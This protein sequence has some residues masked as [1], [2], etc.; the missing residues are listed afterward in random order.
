V[1]TVLQVTIG[2]KP[3]IGRDVLFNFH[4]NGPG[5]CPDVCAYSWQDKGRVPVY[6][7]MVEPSK[8]VAQVNKSEDSGA[9]LWVYGY[10]KAGN[11]IRTEEDGQWVNGYRVPTIYGYAVPDQDAPT[12][13]RVVSVRKAETVGP[14]RLMSYDASATTGTLLGVFQHDETTPEYRQIKLH[15]PA[16]WVRIAFRRRVFR[17]TSQD[18]LIP[19][20]SRA[21]LKMMVQALKYYDEGDLARANTYEATARR[22]ITEAEFASSPPVLSPIQVNPRNTLLDRYDHVS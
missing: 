11:F 8:L 4:L 22:F 1:E 12:F 13:A 6:R 16:E 5:D 21:A 2:G 19:L 14:I 20:H 3:T 18:D 10:D 17:I 15:Q 7:Q 9:E